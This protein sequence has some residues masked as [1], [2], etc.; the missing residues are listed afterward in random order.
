VHPLPRVIEGS[1]AET[2]KEER[3]GHEENKT[4]GAPRRA[5]E[6]HSPMPDRG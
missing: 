4:D 1:A 3:D 2:G 6:I 5:N